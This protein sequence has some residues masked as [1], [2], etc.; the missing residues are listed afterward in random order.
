MASFRKASAGAD[1]EFGR[2]MRKRL[3]QVGSMFL[4]LVASLFLSAGRLDWW[5]G[6]IYLGLLLAAFALQGLVMDRELVAERAGIGPGTK[7]WD[8]VLASVSMLLFLPGSLIVAGLDERLGW[9]SAAPAIQI[10]GGVLFAAAWALSAWAMASNKF[11]STTVRIQEERGHAV[12]SD[13]PYAFV[14]HPGYLAFSLA[15]LATPFLLSSLWALLPALLAVAGVA[16]R[17]VLEERTLRAE[18][19][20]YEEYARQVR[21][22]YLPGIW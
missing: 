8:R 18:L 15:A 9:S 11:F 16:V 1:S 3:V 2:S 21:Y 5:A 7:D 13:G 6:W 10:L 22:R 20:G 4:V 19:P 12:V 17:T 14:R